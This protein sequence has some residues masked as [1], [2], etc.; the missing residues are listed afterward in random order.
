MIKVTGRVHL[1]R[2]SGLAFILGTTIPDATSDGYGVLGYTPAT[3]KDL[4]GDQPI[5]A[6]QVVEGRRIHGACSFTGSGATI[7]GCEIV[8]RPGAAY[9]VNYRGLVSNTQGGINNTVEYSKLTQW[10]ASTNSDNSISWREGI[11][12]TSGSITTRR[13]DISNTNHLM[14]VNGGTLTELGSWLHD[15]GFRTDD[16]DH[17]TDPRYPNW[18]HNDGI[19]F[20]G[21]LNHHVEGTRIDN[22]F[23][24][25]TGMNSTANPDPNAEQIW[26]NAHCMLFRQ[27]NSTL[28]GV[29]LKN[30]F[31]AHGSI[32]MQFTTSTL[33]GG[34]GDWSITGV[35][36]TPNQGKEYGYYQQIT[37]DSS[38]WGNVV[39]DT[40]NVYSDEADTPVAYRGQPLKAPTG[41]APKSWA[42]NATVHTGSIP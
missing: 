37:I 9:D 24:K 39:I 20:A 38:Q 13:L 10:D 4:S 12:L 6:G 14:Y 35:R 26:P 22:T 7:R 27:A 16:T 2:N 29:T 32:A 28:P 17:S 34:G 3:L 1:D 40:S 23:S 19:H 31:L 25:Q 30:I 5:G 36:I 33:T 42:F 21:G 11:Y 15:V 8:S 18:S 41:T